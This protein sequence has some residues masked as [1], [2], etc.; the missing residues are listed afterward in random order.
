MNLLTVELLVTYIT[1]VSDQGANLIEK[2]KTQ[3]Y[4]LIGV[5]HIKTSVYHP[6]A[7]ELIERFNGTLKHMLKK[8]VG[9]QIEYI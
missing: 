3:L 8:F 2:L 1:F 7:N 6:E 9:N 5:S 4:E